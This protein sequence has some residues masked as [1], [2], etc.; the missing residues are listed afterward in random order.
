M[1]E[2][3]RL[4]LEA[5][6]ED[7]RMPFTHI[8]RRAG[9]SET[10]IRTRYRQLVAS[11]VVRTVGVVDPYALGFAAP[12]IIGVSV[13]PGLVDHV[14]TSLTKLP[15]ISYLVTTLGSYDLVVEVFCRD[16][17]HLSGLV[18]EDIRSIPGVRST[19][20]LM[21]SRSFKLSYRWSM[22]LEEQAG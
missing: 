22:D 5:L 2:L 15:E 20:T 4:I 7:G 21:I 9:V 18:T 3:D 19:E 12:A 10:T 13:E 17:A 6:Q 11:G 1:D 14:A 16:V 8:A